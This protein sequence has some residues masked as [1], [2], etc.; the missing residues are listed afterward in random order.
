MRLRKVSLE[1][2]VSSGLAESLTYRA[3]QGFM[4]LG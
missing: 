2:D 3:L 1:M 4:S